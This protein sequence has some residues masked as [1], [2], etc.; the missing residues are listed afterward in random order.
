MLRQILRLLCL[1]LCGAAVAA[2]LH[3]TETKTFSPHRGSAAADRNARSG[4]VPDTVTRVPDVP[5]PGTLRRAVRKSD[6]HDGLRPESRNQALRAEPRKVPG[7]LLQLTTSGRTRPR[8]SA[9]RG[10]TNRTAWESPP[11]AAA[12]EQRP[13]P[14]FRL[15]ASDL[16]EDYPP[17]YSD[18]T[19]LVPVSAR[20][21]RKKP[22]NPFHPVTAESYGACAVLLTAAVIFSVGV[23]G[24]V[25]V[26]CIVCHNYYMRSISNSLLANL[27]L[28]DFAV[29]F[30]CLPLVVV[31][32]L[33]GTWL[34]GEFSCRIVPYLEVRAAS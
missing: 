20:P 2:R 31:H 10:R 7:E 26:M 12:Q 3:W 21:R 14:P 19:Q 5:G 4:G 24:N 18:A 6:A 22:R 30:F 32:E 25:S 28:W 11:A 13:E 34:L 27:A 17:D 15:N 23:V 29:T 33:T 8:R 16:G 9:K 1:W